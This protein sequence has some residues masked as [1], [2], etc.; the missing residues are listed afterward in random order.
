MNADVTIHFIT[1][2][3]CKYIILSTSVIKLKSIS[4]IY[5]IPKKHDA[6]NINIYLHIPDDYYGEMG[7]PVTFLDKHNREQFELV[8]KMT[9]TRIDEYNFGYPYINGRKKFARIIIKRI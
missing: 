5:N 6:I 9:T 3:V 1:S 7:V 2:S 4:V 8:G